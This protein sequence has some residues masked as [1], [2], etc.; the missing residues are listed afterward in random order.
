LRN[1]EEEN[2]NIDLH[3]GDWNCI[4]RKEDTTG[5]AKIEGKLKNYIKK[6]ELKD[7][8]DVA[9]NTKGHFTW[10]NGK[11]RTR[12]DRIYVKKRLQQMVES[13]ETIKLAYS[14][15]E[16]VILT[17]KHTKPEE[18]SNWKMK[19]EELKKTENV[20]AIRKV[21]EAIKKS[22][23]PITEKWLK[24]KEAVINISKRTKNQKPSTAWRFQNERGT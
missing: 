11:V 4:T 17:L 7:V 19:E 5:T 10:T 18:K 21:I 14:D 8:I 23:A 16:M 1:L 3:L 13:L 22:K 15:H 20:E 6:N 24:L 2:E 12:I 9:E